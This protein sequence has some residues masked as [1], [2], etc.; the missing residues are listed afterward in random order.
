M[1]DTGELFL[2]SLWPRWKSV[3]RYAPKI[4]SEKRFIY[5]P[6]PAG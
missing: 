3:K 5:A 2:Q 1:A 6:L 4:R